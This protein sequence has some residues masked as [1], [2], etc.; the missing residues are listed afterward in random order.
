MAAKAKA[1][2]ARRRFYGAI[3]AIDTLI[4]VLPAKF[5]APLTEHDALA[6]QIEHA[7]EPYAEAVARLPERD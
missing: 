1:V 5:E 6:D 4:A 2:Q 7:V 3:R